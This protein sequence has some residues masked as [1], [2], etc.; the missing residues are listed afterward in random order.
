MHMARESTPKSCSN[1]EKRRKAK[2]PVNEEG[3]PTPA[4]TSPVVVVFPPDAEGKQEGVYVGDMVET[5][6]K[7]KFNEDNEE[8]IDVDE[9]E[10]TD[11]EDEDVSGTTA[12]PRHNASS[13]PRSTH[14][15]SARSTGHLKKRRCTYP[16]SNK[17]LVREGELYAQE[18]AKYM[19]RKTQPFYPRFRNA[20]HS[21]SP[22]LP[23]DDKGAATPT[24][25]ETDIEI[26]EPK[27]GIKKN[28]KS[29]QTTAPTHAGTQKVV[30]PT[31]SASTSQAGTAAQRASQSLYEQK[32]KGKRRPTALEKREAALANQRA[33]LEQKGR[34]LRKRYAV[35]LKDAWGGVQKAQ[36]A[37]Q[38]SRIRKPSL[39]ERIG[40]CI[41]NFMFK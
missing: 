22:P 6:T 40:N 9:G 39:L 26:A 10:L 15:N 17:K 31:T 35:I 19:H 24:D 25:S 36:N 18:I 21:P 3:S 4:V 30:A 14:S 38:R 11:D 2:A 1:E 20:L 7:R 37:Q 32:Q 5:K 41:H 23:T 28:P 12:G 29:G 27:E 8:L 13:P 34:E 16:S 33:D